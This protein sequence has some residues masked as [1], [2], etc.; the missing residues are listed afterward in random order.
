MTEIKKI[1]L[2]LKHNLKTMKRYLKLSKNNFNLFIKL[3]S[4]LV[5]SLFLL[6]PINIKATQETSLQDLARKI[7][8]E[9]VESIVIKGSSS[10]VNI[11]LKDGSYLYSN[12][13]S[14]VPLEQS[15]LDYGV[16]ADKIKNVDIKIKGDGLSVF[17]P[18]LIPFL[19]PILL[20]S[21]LYFIVLVGFRILHI[22]NIPK[23]KISVYVFITFIYS[24]FLS[25]ATATIVYK[26]ITKNEFAVNFID[27]IFSFLITFL[28]IKYYFLL[29]GKKLW[30]FLLYLVVIGLIF[31][32]VV[33]S[34]FLL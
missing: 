20:F 12:K 11:K 4:T 26:Y 23:Q 33:N 19:F 30:Q 1:W 9:E 21:I 18:L 15:L 3:I 14:E 10:R 24:L 22:E 25:P 32:L 28:I 6:L 5:L 13:D 2:F 17:I 29:S 31:S 34:I 7:Q 8:N 16:D 27:Y